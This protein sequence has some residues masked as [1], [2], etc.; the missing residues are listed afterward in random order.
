MHTHPEETAPEPNKPFNFDFSKSSRFNSN[1]WVLCV[2][3]A[4]VIMAV[5]ALRDVQETQ[6]VTFREIVQTQKDA[7]AD[8]LA[9]LE[10]A[11]RQE[12]HIEFADARIDQL[13]KKNASAD[14]TLGVIKTNVDW[15]V[16]REGKKQ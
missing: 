11:Q 13:E 8:K 6:R 12:K 14:Y 10:R 7:A 3:I 5:T 15:L 9:L 2:L 16:M 4:F 1:L